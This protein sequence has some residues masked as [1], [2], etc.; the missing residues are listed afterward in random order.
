MKTQR[1][2]A[3]PKVPPSSCGDRSRLW[4]GLIVAAAA[5]IAGLSLAIA[6][7][8]KSV[9]NRVDAE[10]QEAVADGDAAAQAERI[11]ASCLATLG[12]ADSVSLRLRQ[13]VRVGTKVLVGTGRYVQEGRG[14]VQRFRFE[15]SLTC[16]TESF[17]T[18]EVSD[19]LFFWSHRRISDA[20]PELQR[21]DIQR[22]RA[23]LEEMKVP[24]P[25]EASPYLGGFQ[26]LLWWTRQW[27]LFSSAVPGELEGRSVWL[28]SGRMP[29]ALVA[30]VMPEL[31]EAAKQPDGLRPE[32]MPDGWP[33]EVR[34]A[35]GR[36]DLLPHRLEF[37]AIPGPRPVTNHDVV[38]IAVIDI[39]DIELNGR[40]DP[41]AFFYQP[42][43]EGLVDVTTNHVKTM[44]ILRP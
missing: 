44:A 43:S 32:M 42:A 25:Q 39:L 16:D 28:V 23:R 9:Y 35:V 1:P 41:A 18:T 33:W 38:P 7:P 21:V 40:V 12:G 8:P 24:K 10:V 14:E 30:H 19:G 2:A 22:V 17:E 3:L 4:G 20:P 36:A 27:F 34:L 26:R 37:L 5:S 29:P 6:A 31:A 11:V 13:K 15:S